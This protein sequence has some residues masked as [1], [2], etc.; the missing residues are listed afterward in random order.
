MSEFSPFLPSPFLQGVLAAAREIAPKLL[1]RD[2]ALLARHT[3]GAGGDISI[4][5]DLLC[6]AI[7]VKHLSHIAHIDSEESGLLESSA[8]ALQDLPTIVLDPLDGSDNY[9]SGLPYYGASLA[10]C[11]SSGQVLEAAVINYCSGEVFYDALDSGTTAR[12]SSPESNALESRPNPTPE[13]KRDSSSPL[14]HS[15]ALKLHFPTHSHLPLAHTNPK[16]G[17]FEKAYSHPKLAVA[18]R[19]RGCKFR[20]LGASALSLAYAL[21]HG[22]FLFAGSIRRYDALAGRFLCR[23]LHILEQSD[24][25]LVS[26]NQQVFGMIREILNQDRHHQDNHH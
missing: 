25:L 8:K 17:V 6:E 7:F 20:S 1:T 23:N 5:A 26:Q 19:D 16:C 4:G 13:S 10:L 18:L 9:C 2:R 15:S 21:E 12:E 14:P 22:F 24:L 3:Q 11:D